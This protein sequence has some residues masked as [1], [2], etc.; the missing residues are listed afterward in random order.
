MKRIVKVF[1]YMFYSILVLILCVNIVI[2]IKANLYK[3]K[4]PGILGYK[5]FVVLS[6]SMQSQINVGDLVI[7]R[8][9]DANKLNVNDIIAYRDGKI[10]T[11][12]RIKEVLKDNNDVCFKT[13]GDSNNTMDD[14]VVCSK[15]IEGRYVFKIN[16]LGNLIIFIQQPTGFFIMLLSI[17]L[18]GVLV[19]L[20]KNREINKKF[21]IED[22]EERKAFEEFKKSR[23][24]KYDVIFLAGSFT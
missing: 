22:E 24:K 7:V 5:P 1:E 23:E 10:V 17:L 14:G 8:E 3:D 2:M 18:I 21:E 6:G 20:I 12:H 15:D 16:K 13:K 4:V 19:F 9:I 11:T